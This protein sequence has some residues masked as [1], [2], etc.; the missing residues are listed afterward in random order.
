MNKNVILR[1][2]ILFLI[3][4]H[5][6]G[7][8]LHAQETHHE[9]RANLLYPAFGLINMQYEFH[10]ASRFS[11]GLSH[12]IGLK[13]EN[14]NWAT[15]VFTRY[16]PRGMNGRGFFTEA[17]VSLWEDMGEKKWRHLMGG[18]SC[19]YKSY[20]NNRLHAEALLGLGLNLKNWG[21]SELGNIGLPRVG[22]LL[23]SRL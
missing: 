18:F 10:N 4:Q 14:Y 3:F 16:Y 22:L 19:G 12:T 7:N 17:H 23:G 13:K 9:V 11:V 21:G 5:Q 2:H 6:A 1:I 20:F 8:N 15:T